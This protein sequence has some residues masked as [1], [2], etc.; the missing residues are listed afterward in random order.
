M[1]VDIIALT[2]TWLTPDVA[3]T[4]LQLNDFKLFR[5]DRSSNRMG[6]GVL[7]Y[8]RSYLR[9][10]LVKSLSDASSHEEFVS[11][12]IRHS[13][14]GGS[15]EIAV[16]YRPPDSDGELT[17]KE[18]SRVARN[19]DCL[20][21]G[22]FN[23]PFID[24]SDLVILPG[25][26]CFEKEFLDLILSENL[27]QAVLIPT[28]ILPDQVPH[29]LDLIFTHNKREISNLDCLSPL[30][31]SDHMLLNFSWSRK[32]VTISSSPRRNVWKTD[33]DGMKVAAAA[34]SWE[35]CHEMDLEDLCNFVSSTIRELYERFTPLSKRSRSR[36]QP[37]WF[38]RELKSKIK[39]RKRLWDRFKLTKCSSDYTAYKVCRNVC[40]DLKR[41]K[42]ISYER[43][44]AN[45]STTAPKKLFAY[46]RRNT[47]TCN[48]I[49]PLI[50]PDNGC[51]FESDED[52]ASILS[53]QYSSVF[54]VEDDYSARIPDICTNILSDC[55]FTTSDVEAIL[56]SLN[57]QSSPGPDELHPRILKNLAPFICEPLALLFRKSLD[58]GKLPSSWKDALVK[59]IFKGGLQEDPSN[60][61]PV[62]LTSV[63]CKVLEK[64]L[65]RTI[66]Q[67]FR[68]AALWTSA[69]H[70]FREARSCTTN[71]LLAKELWAESLDEGSRLDVVY[72]DFSKAFDRVPHRRLL[73]KMS[74]YGISGNLHAWI[75]DFLVGRRM[76]VKVN[77]CLSGWVDC[78]SGVPQGSVLGPLLFK[79]YIND[80]PEN[81]PVPCLLYA[82]D[83]K[84]WA[85]VVSEPDVD[86][87]QAAL[88][89][90]HSWSV[91]WLLPFN[92]TKCCVLPIGGN[93]P[94]GVYHLGGYLLREEV[95][96]RDLGILM[97]PDLKMS[98]ET[99][100]R[101]TAASKLFWAIRRSFSCLTIEIFRT[102][103]MSH[104]RPILEY[105]QPAFHPILKQD[106][107]RLENVQR[108][109]SKLVAGL[110]NFSYEE[111]LTKLDMFTLE[112][113]RHRA[114][115]I[116]TWRV[117]HGVLDNEFSRFFEFDTEKT[118]RGHHLKLFKRRRF[119]LNPMITLSTRVINAW[120]ALPEDVVS[121]ESET[122]FKRK[123]DQHFT[124]TSGEPC[125][126]CQ[127]EI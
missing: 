17:L 62:S 70:G 27:E 104:V 49:P 13:D 47:K 101:A 118:T 48:G 33:L 72:V 16:L 77:D 42:R 91:R 28:R 126:F 6:G 10:S 2:E 123:L 58:A 103:F 125:S 4:E 38:D 50:N 73:D 95:I 54:V 56:L 20:I 94:V 52:I 11:C 79:V 43:S 59:P 71:L 57:E 65:K 40:S 24:W 32:Y 39:E 93:Q 87:F 107:R 12:R 127:S 21:L 85:P 105:G 108:R 78:S 29:T 83:L 44:L 75:A 1:Q 97:S 64:I 120:N 60:Y 9:P 18:L 69:Q 25:H 41:F 111:R 66:E 55:S 109:G 88:D 34:I 14:V 90:L 46:L 124:N 122:V 82:D 68:S 86:A 7:L 19:V 117:T 67:H 102:L 98:D 61:R 63:L 96:E 36:Q 99:K 3:D 31:A 35:K 76:R 37:P 80:L 15:A 116:Y 113:R 110:K 84:L 30:G 53:S 112:H 92:Y 51:I 23:A 106:S 74:A 100:R 121:A 89:A 8:C 45:S 119:R 22:D 114:D 5:A 26:N 81:L 115:L